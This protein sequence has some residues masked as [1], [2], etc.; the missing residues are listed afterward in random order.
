M[1]WLKCLPY[2]SMYVCVSECECVWHSLQN[3][4]VKMT[5][6]QCQQRISRCQIP[7]HT[8]DVCVLLCGWLCCGHVLA[9]YA[10]LMPGNAKL[11]NN[12][13]KLPQRAW[14]AEAAIVL[15]CDKHRTESA[16]RD[17]LRYVNAM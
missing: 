17:R 13:I 15:E 4:F 6:E 3:K 7:P 1:C 8:P 10:A 2:V 9:N 14:L 11:Y 12:D 16:A 5:N